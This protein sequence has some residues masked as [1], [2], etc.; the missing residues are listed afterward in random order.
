MAFSMLLKEKGFTVNVALISIAM[1]FCYSGSAEDVFQGSSIEKALSCFDNKLIYVGCDAAY[2]L[3]PSG[4]INIPPDAID[5]FCSGPCLAETQL[6]LNCID[7]LVSSFLFYN[8]AN[9]EQ[10]RYVLNA[11]CSYSRQRG[12][13]NLG[14]YTG[15]EVNSALKESDLIRLY[16]FIPMVAAIYL[17]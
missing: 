16:L 12:N 5:V 15:E 6:M 3:N 8:K 2:R 14:D 10:I 17:M 4:N 13:F 1:F 7:N 9:V 11:G